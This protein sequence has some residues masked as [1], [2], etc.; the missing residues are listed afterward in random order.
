MA[1]KE[2]AV[3]KK[4]VAPKVVT[5]PKAVK[6]K[7]EFVSFTVRAVVPTQSYGNIQPEITVKAP[8]FEEAR[9]FAMPK[10]EALYKQYAEI[11]PAFLG[12]VTEEVKIIA[13]T[14][15]AYTPAS[16]TPTAAVAPTPVAETTSVPVEKST[17]VQKAEKMIALAASEDALITI[18]NQVNASTKLTDAEKPD[19]AIQILKRR[20]E[21]A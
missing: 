18:Q 10:I 12:K 7:V 16:G 8:T 19:L 6:S 2:K 9:D 13:P 21:F 4:I 1:T 3:V 11:K 14:S 15:G 20:N 17:S 5:K